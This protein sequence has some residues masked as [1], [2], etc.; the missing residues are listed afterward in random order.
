MKLYRRDFT[1]M[2]KLDNYIKAKDMKEYFLQPL[3]LNYQE[4]TSIEQILKKK[5]KIVL[6]LQ[7]LY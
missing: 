1:D 7:E 2:N 4:M 6:L 5:M 3:Q